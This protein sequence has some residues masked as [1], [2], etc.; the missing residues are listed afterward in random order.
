MDTTE[1]AVN[2]FPILRD[3]CVRDC[4]A[5]IPEIAVPVLQATTQMYA[6]LGYEEPWICYLAVNGPDVVGTCGFKGPVR[7]NRVEIAYFT[8]RAFEG[9]GYATAMARQLVA[10][11]REHPARPV[12][13]AQTLPQRSP[14]HRILEKLSFRHVQTLQDPEDGTVWEWRWL[15]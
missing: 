11:A 8:F 15:G 13:A 12:I 10:I 6:A 5:K 9:R 7:N 2:L 3:G 1:S 14:S 4:A